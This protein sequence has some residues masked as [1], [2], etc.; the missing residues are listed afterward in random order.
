MM[1]VYSLFSDLA[2]YRHLFLFCE[3]Q[4]GEIVVSVG[5]SIMIIILV[6]IPGEVEEVLRP[7]HFVVEVLGVVNHQAEFHMFAEVDAVEVVIPNSA[8]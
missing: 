7:V 8:I 3:S 6:F 1:Y 5:N 2:L 4:S